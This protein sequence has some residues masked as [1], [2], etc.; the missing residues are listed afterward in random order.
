M[1]ADGYFAIVDRL[2]DMIIV[3]GANVY[4]SEVEDVLA[5]HPA[6]AEA[7]VIGIPDDHKGEVPKAY[8]VLRPAATATASDLRAYCV[9]NLSSYKVPV[10]IEIRSELPKTMIGKVL[11]RE[12]ERE[13]EATA[14]ARSL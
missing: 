9:E 10:D 6:V 5:A 12:L 4:P 8:V 7:S 2:K 1:D 3:S 11:R 14:S 13:H